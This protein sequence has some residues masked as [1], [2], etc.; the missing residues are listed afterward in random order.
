MTKQNKNT[1]DPI[2]LAQPIAIQG[3]K[4]MSVIIEILF[5]E[6][7]LPNCD[8]DDLFYYGCLFLSLLIARLPEKGRY[9]YTDI[10]CKVLT[11]QAEEGMSFYEKLLSTKENSDQGNQVLQ[12]FSKAYKGDSKVIQD[13]VID[14]ANVLDKITMQEDG[15]WKRN[16]QATKANIRKTLEFVLVERFNTL[17]DRVVADLPP[18]SDIFPDPVLF[19][20]SV[21]TANIGLTAG[22][23]AKILRQSLDEFMREGIEKLFMMVSVSGF[24]KNK[25]H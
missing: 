21:C 15:I 18:Q 20:L 12:E 9:Y 22:C 4:A 25:L 17:I 6:H 2:E 24:D 10:I 13:N 19:F 7:Q 23:G 5:R 16:D 14:V 1:S 11:E 8:M 3:S